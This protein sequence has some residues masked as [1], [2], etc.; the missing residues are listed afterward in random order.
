MGS[1]GYDGS[2]SLQPI[3]LL[4]SWFIFVC[5]Y[6]VQPIKD[7]YRVGVFVWW[8]HSTSPSL[9][10]GCLISFLRCMHCMKEHISVNFTR[11][12]GYLQMLVFI[13]K[14]QQLECNGS[15]DWK[16]FLLAIRK[17]I[18]DGHLYYCCG[19]PWRRRGGGGG[20]KMGQTFCYLLSTTLVFPWRGKGDATK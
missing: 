11:G 17:R 5:L 6:Y 20:T 18:V 7:L 3:K 8:P 15:L 10:V 4:G 16:D 14:L 19:R 13:C 12:Q 9:C 1:E 2:F